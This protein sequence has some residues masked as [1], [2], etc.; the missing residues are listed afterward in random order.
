MKQSRPTYHRALAV[1]W[2][3]LLVGL[4]VVFL[5]TDVS[6]REVLAALFDFFTT[7]WWGIGLFLLL[8]IARPLTLIPMSIFSVLSGV[9]F[10]L[11][12]GAVVVYAGIVISA[13]VSYLVGRWLR[14]AIFILPAPP[15]SDTL[16]RRR[17]FEMITGLHLT[18]LPFDLINYGAGLL[19]LPWRPFLGGVLIGMIPGTISLTALG[20]AVNLPM[21]LQGEVSWNLFNWWY[22]GLSALIFTATLLGS[23]YWR[24][25]TATG[26]AMKADLD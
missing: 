24:R 19:H 26:N 13:G 1:L 17:P 22:L 18:M 11:W 14:Q 23:Y 5:L 7:S 3:S 4:Y 6:A 20:A 15:V 8:Y 16:L 9:F 21:V 25:Y 10:G 12:L 2:L